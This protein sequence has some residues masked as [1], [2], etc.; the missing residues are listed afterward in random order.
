MTDI[1]LLTGGNM[2]DRLRYLEKA[3]QFIES[4]VD[5][6]VKKSS[7]YETAAWGFTEQQAFLNQVICVNT[8]LK[9]NELLQELLSIELQLGRERV[10]KMGPRVIDIDILFYSNQVISTANLVVPH[11]RMAERRFVLV[12]LNEIAPGFI[13]PV[14]NKTV[15]QLLEICLDLLE[16]KLYKG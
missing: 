3:C 2:G 1:Y 13:H 10:E 11:P 5:A 15:N 9:P 4:K 12:P 6:V 16:V 8:E 7:I 14:F